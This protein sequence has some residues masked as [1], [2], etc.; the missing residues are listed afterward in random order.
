MDAVAGGMNLAE[1]EGVSPPVPISRNG[2]RDVV[3]HG[4]EMQIQE[5]IY[6]LIYFAWE[7]LGKTEQ[8]GLQVEARIDGEQDCGEVS[9]RSLKP[10]ESAPEGGGLSEI[11]LESRGAEIGTGSNIARAI[12]EAHGGKL[13]FFTKEGTIE[14]VMRLPLARGSRNR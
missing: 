9:I 13:Q 7:L 12:V 4:N 5:A 3:I 11:N 2:S 8:Q 14:F 10:N 1:Q 6:H